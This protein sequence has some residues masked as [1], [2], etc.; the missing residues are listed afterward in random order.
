MLYIYINFIQF[1]SIMFHWRLC[2]FCMHLRWRSAVS[3]KQI[4]W[5]NLSSSKK[6]KKGVNDQIYISLLRMSQLQLKVLKYSPWTGWNIVMW[7]LLPAFSYWLYNIWLGSY[8]CSLVS[9]IAVFDFKKFNFC[10]QM[11]VSFC[12]MRV[13]II[14]HV[15][16]VIC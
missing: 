12:I 15:L 13:C 3:R 5:L 14:P 4:C 9:I 11:S 6:G 1:F 16:L 8:F 10:K 2:L 7:P